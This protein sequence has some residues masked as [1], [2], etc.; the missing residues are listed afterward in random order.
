[1]VEWIKASLVKERTTATMFDGDVTK[2]VS[3]KSFFR[4]LYEARYPEN[5]IDEEDVLVMRKV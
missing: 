1:M 5:S 3:R 4:R 2:K